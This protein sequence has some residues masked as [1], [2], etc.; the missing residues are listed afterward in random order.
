MSA[1]R[2]VSLILLLFLFGIFS[3]AIQIPLSTNDVETPDQ[4]TRVPVTLGVM[5]RCPDALL[6][7]SVL[8]GVFKKTWDLVDVNL[9]FIAQ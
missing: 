8:D 3:N 5:S 7:E 1:R 6:C 2:S 9:T 4:K